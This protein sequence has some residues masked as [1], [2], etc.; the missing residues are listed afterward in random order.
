MSWHREA[1]C[2]DV[3]DFTEL[4]PQ[5]ARPVCH[6]C[7]VRMECLADALDVEERTWHGSRAYLGTVRGGLSTYQRMKLLRSRGTSTEERTAS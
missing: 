1:A 6:R 2:R 4:T 7:P 5:V 3:P